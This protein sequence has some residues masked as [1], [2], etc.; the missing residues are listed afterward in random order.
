MLSVNIQTGLL[1]E[2]IQRESPNSDERPEPQEISLIVIHGISLPPAEFG[3]D[4]IEKFFT[5]TLDFQAHPY[6]KEIKDLKVSSH[7]LIERDGEI[8]QFVPFHKRAWHAGVSQFEKRECCNDFSIGIELEGTDNIQ[9]TEQ[10]YQVL[11]DVCKSL[12]NAYP[13]LSESTIVGHCDIAPGRKTDP[14]ESFDWQRFK[15]NLA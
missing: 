10:Q 8:K 11:Q 5:N 12:I 9:Y 7:L 15:A 6:F 2:A 14:G 4:Y 13:A 3:G 1:N